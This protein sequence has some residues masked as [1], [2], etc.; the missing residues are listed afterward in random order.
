MLK[1]IISHLKKKKK[2]HNR[3]LKIEMSFTS[4]RARDSALFV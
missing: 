2:S 3:V 4:N 1:K